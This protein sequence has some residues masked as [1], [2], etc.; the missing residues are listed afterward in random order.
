MNAK[1]RVQQV[2]ECLG[3]RKVGPVILWVFDVRYFS[4]F[5]FIWK[6]GSREKLKTQGRGRK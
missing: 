1:G 3:V 6:E 2:E 4:L 5:K